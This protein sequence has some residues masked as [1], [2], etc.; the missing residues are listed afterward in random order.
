M[1]LTPKDQIILLAGRD[2]DAARRA[3][4]WSLPELSVRLARL[5]DAGLVDGAGLSE[6][7]GVAAARRIHHIT[8]DE[9]L[10]E[11]LPAEVES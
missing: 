9:L 1:N 11:H 2:A 3:R 4:I 7:D 8:L 6:P 10:A 5:T